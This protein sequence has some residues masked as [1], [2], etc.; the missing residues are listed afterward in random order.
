VLY[1]QYGVLM[2]AVATKT[3]GAVPVGAPEPELRTDVD[4][5][6]GLT[7]PRTRL[8]FLAN[9]NNP[10]GCLLPDAE[11]RRLHAGLRQDVLLV[12]DSAYAEYVGGED[13]QDGARLVRASENVVMLRTF[14]KIH[15]LAALRIGWAY[16]PPSVA[17]VLHRVRN[18]FN[19]NAP[20]QAAALAAL[21]D[22]DHAAAGRAHNDR[23]LPWF[24]DQLAARGYAALASA[25][26]FV[27]ARFGGDT[28]A[29]T[30]RL[31]RHGIIPRGMR[32]YGLPE[33]LRITIGLEHELRA[34]LAALD[35]LAAD[36]PGNRWRAGAR[37]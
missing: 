20:A 26:N 37:P 12:L 5:L 34:V 31:H 16:G 27:L 1:S 28:E 9:P 7:T 8:L 2:Y 22:R 10:T 36:R 6:L 35:E 24:R 3:V 25:G 18:P 17:D 4:A 11:V 14:S 29:V 33:Y 23:W 13:Y 15:C 19:V 21:T 32:P 30:A